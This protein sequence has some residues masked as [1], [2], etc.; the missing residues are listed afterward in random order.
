M[1]GFDPAWPAGEQEA[2][3]LGCAAALAAQ[4]V[5][6]P[7]AVVGQE[8]WAN[9][10]NAL[11][12]VA[13]AAYEAMDNSEERANASGGED[14]EYIIQGNDFTALSAAMDQIDALPDDRPGYT[15]SGGA[16]ASWALRDLFTAPVPAAGVQGSKFDISTPDRIRLFDLDGMLLNYRCAATDAKR[17]EFK[18]AIVAAFHALANHPQPDS[19]RDAALSIK[20]WQE[21]VLEKLHPTERE[22]QTES[23]LLR[24]AANEPFEEIAEL[25]AALAAHPASLDGAAA[26]V[27]LGRDIKAAMNTA[28]T[29]PEMRKWKAH[30]ATFDTAAHP[31]NGAQAELSDAQ[32]NEIGDN[33]DSDRSARN[34]RQFHPDRFVYCARAILAATKKGS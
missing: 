11:L 30:L 20:K 5:Q 2:W 18:A 1:R 31:A 21:R 8:R 7:A 24:N 14:A 12:S 10:I 4:P 28:L 9:A 26:W 25:R 29:L 33:W 15:L 13:T 27:A 6:Q 34:F 17:D 22:C 19:G 32:I 23:T 3:R 16:R